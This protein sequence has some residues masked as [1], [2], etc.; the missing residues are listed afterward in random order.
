MYAEARIVETMVA[1][2]SSRVGSTDSVVSVEWHIQQDEAAGLVVL[3]SRSDLA[4]HTA[5]PADCSSAEVG[6]PASDYYLAPDQI[7]VFGSV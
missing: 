6:V 3:D 7:V 1:L 2:R 5:N 4:S